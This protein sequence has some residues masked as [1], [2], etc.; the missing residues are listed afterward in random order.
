MKAFMAN[1][2]GRLDDWLYARCQAFLHKRGLSAVKLVE[3]AG[4]VYLVDRLGVYHKV[5]G[6]KP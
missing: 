1:L 5:Q 3:R 2:R 6:L 4:T